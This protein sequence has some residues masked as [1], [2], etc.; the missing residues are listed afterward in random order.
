MKLDTKVLLIF[1][2]KT[3]DEYIT[4]STTLL[5]MLEKDLETFYEELEP[6]CT[7]SSC[8]NESQNFCDCGSAYEDFEIFEVKLPQGNLLEDLNKTL[9][10]R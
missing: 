6:P 8:N 9:K 3:E 10:R 2:H 4:A 7:S 5:G 1:K